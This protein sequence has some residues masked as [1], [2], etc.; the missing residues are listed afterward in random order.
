MWRPVLVVVLLTALI[1]AWLRS[2][3][4]AVVTPAS[5]DAPAAVAYGEFRTLFAQGGRSTEMVFLLEFPSLAQCSQAAVL[6]AFREFCS[7]DGMSCR[8]D[9]LV[10]REDLAPRY[11]RMLEGQ[12]VALH[13]ARIVFRLSRS[14][15]RPRMVGV[16]WGATVEESMSW[17]LKSIEDWPAERGDAQCI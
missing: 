8:F 11:R 7:R 15:L 14:P 6:S 4:P 9:T 17:C 2:Q 13:Y 5:D 1:G 12:P 3:A 10:C 16:P